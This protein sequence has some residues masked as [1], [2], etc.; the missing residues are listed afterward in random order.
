MVCGL[1]SSGSEKASVKRS[2]VYA[3]VGVKRLQSSGL[4]SSGSEKAS[5]KWSVV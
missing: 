4:W 2:V 5:V 1:C 3:L